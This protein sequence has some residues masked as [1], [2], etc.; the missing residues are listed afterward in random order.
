MLFNRKSTRNKIRRGFFVVI[1]V[2]IAIGLVVPLAG[3]FSNQPDYSGRQDS[4][5]VQQTLGERLAE[6][7][8]KVKENPG[9]VN[10]L[11]ELA[12]TY[13]YSG[14]RDQAVTTYEQ[15]LALD[16][17][18]SHARF[19]LA[20]IYY[21][22]SEYDLAVTQLQELLKNEPDNKDARYFYGI[23]LGT[24]LKDY[25]GGIKELEKFIELAGEGTDVEKV[26]QYIDEWK[27]AIAQ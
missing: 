5:A 20:T 6:L 22:T 7:E 2:L 1:T 19:D 24:G 8:N 17:N 14:N 26:R 16:P 12:Q 4:G 10:T 23:V 25:Q 3:L 13:F 11:I 9:D 21:Y 18:N 15:V 27:A